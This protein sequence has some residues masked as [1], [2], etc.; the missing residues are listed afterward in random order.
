[1]CCRP[2]QPLTTYSIDSARA[3][4]T[5]YQIYGNFLAS[6]VYPCISLPGMPRSLFRSPLL[7]CLFPFVCSA[8]LILSNFDT[9]APLPVCLVQVEGEVEGQGQRPLEGPFQ[10]PFPRPVQGP[11]QRSPPPRR[12]PR[13]PQVSV[14]L[15]VPL[16]CCCFC[17]CGLGVLCFRWSSRFLLFPPYFFSLVQFVRRYL[18]AVCFAL[19]FLRA[20]LLNVQPWRRG[21]AGIL[22]LPRVYHLKIHV[23]TRD[24]K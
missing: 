10:G 18:L 23:Y 4:S 5:K 15:S 6:A 17:L 11:V 2:I 21:L 22:C 3:L 24:Y 7:G 16:L 9:D 13:A 8:G 20:M 1:M 19:L 12:Q 14:S